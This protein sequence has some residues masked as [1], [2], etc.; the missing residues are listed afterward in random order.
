[1][2]TRAHAITTRDAMIARMIA[3][4]RIERAHA[5]EIDDEH[6]HVDHDDA[7]AFIVSSHD[8][9]AHDARAYVAHVTRDTS[10]A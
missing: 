1:M 9:D 10:R 3:R 6:A 8:D 7:R 4:R 5:R 2:L